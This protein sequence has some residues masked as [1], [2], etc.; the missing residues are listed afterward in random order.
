[1][2]EAGWELVKR[3]GKPEALVMCYEEEYGL[4]R[5][6]CELGIQCLV[7]APSLTPV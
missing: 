4:Q 6:L 1:M 5:P 3:L 2:P 7:A